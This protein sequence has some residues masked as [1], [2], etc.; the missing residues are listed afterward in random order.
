MSV[1]G[2]TVTTLHFIMRP[3]QQSILT[4]EVSVDILGVCVCV[5]HGNEQQYDSWC[6]T[7]DTPP[8]H[9]SLTQYCFAQWKSYKSSAAL[10]NSEK[11]AMS[12]GAEALFW[13][14]ES[15]YKWKRLSPESQHVETDCER[16]AS[17]A[18]PPGQLH[19]WNDSSL[20]TQRW[21]LAVLEYIIHC[22]TCVQYRIDK[23]IETTKTHHKHKHTE[24]I[25]LNMR[26]VFVMDEPYCN[27]SHLIVFSFS[28]QTSHWY[29][30]GILKTY[31]WSKIKF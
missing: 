16:R 15:S 25:A 24:C 23:A 3:C 5:S 22:Y 26:L 21:P 6:C 28:N 8:K 14:R 10:L 31:N 1:G 13:Q 2:R 30:N 18:A 4:E 19:I 29:W 20:T 9:L 12:C 27:L 17:R 7:C 11:A